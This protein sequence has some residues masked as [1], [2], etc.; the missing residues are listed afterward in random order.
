MADEPDRALII[1]GVVGAALLVGFTFF[2]VSRNAD[3]QAQSQPQPSTPEQTPAPAPTGP[4]TP[5]TT[6]ALTISGDQSIG[7][8][9]GQTLL[10][11]LPDPP[12]GATGWT[13]LVEN[14]DGQVSYLPR[15]PNQAPNTYVITAISKGISVIR[16]AP[17]D[18][19][20]PRSALYNLTVSVQ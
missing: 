19:F 6:Y 12:A 18:Q 2:L 17:S 7:L 9:S 8:S 11:T 10:A 16:F 4:V 13:L 15:V 14:H 1:T 5:A 20:G 3:A